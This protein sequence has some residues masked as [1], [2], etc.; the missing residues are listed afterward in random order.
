MYRRH[1]KQAEPPEVVDSVEA[2]LGRDTELRGEIAK[3]FATGQG[4]IVT[5]TRLAVAMVVGVAI[6]AVAMPSRLY[7]NRPASSNAHV[8]TQRS[9]LTLVDHG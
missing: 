1:G 8:A 6:L 2:I 5:R 4:R 3:I 9:T 7:R